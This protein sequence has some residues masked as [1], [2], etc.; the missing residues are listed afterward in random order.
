MK[1]AIPVENRRLH[2]HFGGCR[3]FALVEV[4]V[5]QKLVLRT[6]IVSAPEH[7]PG[8]FPRWLRE[9]GV[10]VVI[11]GGIGCRALAIFSHHGITVRAG[12]ANAAIE[13]LLAAYLSGQ[14]TTT[15]DGCNHHDPEQYHHHSHAESGE[16][17]H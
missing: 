13:P 9:R 6:E 2:G 10:Q 3:Q 5:E 17:V 16:E 12:R 1:I 7:Q 4:D 14:L 15:P 8:L 11:A